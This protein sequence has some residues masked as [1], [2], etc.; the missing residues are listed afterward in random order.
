[1]SR[2]TLI[3]NL[4]GGAGAGK[5]TLASALFAELKKSGIEA[6]LV[7]EYAKELVWEDN[8]LILQ[9]QIKIFGEQNHRLVRLLGKV[10]VIVTDSPILLGILYDKTDNKQLHSLI[11]NTFKKY[12]NKNF[13]ILRE[14]DDYSTIG[15]LQTEDEAKEIDNK[16]I[17]M[18]INNDIP[19]VSMHRD[20][21]RVTREVLI[22]LGVEE[23]GVESEDIVGGQQF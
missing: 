2:E 10:D 3:V 12:N 23:L 21:S 6:E 20:V 9:D 4:F 13:F 7:T 5:S 22:T 8:S 11:T 19:Y 15:R 1:M 18:L 16:I 17:K 14:E